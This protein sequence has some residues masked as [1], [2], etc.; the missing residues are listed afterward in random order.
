MK[1]TNLVIVSFIAVGLFSS[2]VGG[3]IYYYTA[4]DLME[5]KIN[6]SLL[7]I[8]ESR[9]EH[10]ETL[11]EQLR[12]SVEIAATHSELTTEELQYIREIEPDFFEIFVMD[13]NGVIVTSTDSAKVGLDR[14]DDEY[15]VE[16]RE[17]THLKNFY[18]SEDTQRNAMAIST[19]HAGGVLVARF[20]L[21]AL[22]GIARDRTGLGETGEVLVAVKEDDELV[23][24]FDRL[25]E[26]DVAIGEEFSE[27]SAE[28][29]T[30]ALLGNELIFRSA[31]DYRNV[32][33]IAA[34]QYI[35]IIDMGLVAK[36]DHEEI[37]GSY[38]QLLIKNSIFI[39]IL[40]VLIS[41]LI[42]IIVFRKKL[43]AIN[44]LEEGARIIGDGN[45][46]HRI[47][48]QSKDEIG[49]L[50]NSFNKMAGKLKKSY[51]GL[52]QRVN[53]RT[54]ELEYAKTGLEKKVQEQTI[55]LQKRNKDL[56]AA[57]T[58]LEKKVQEQTAEIQRKLDEVES[59]NKTM[60]GREL[61]MVE[62]K[63]KID[64]LNKQKT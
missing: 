20:D 31:L 17:G 28:P 61:K 21:A 13:A 53:E 12:A 56:L 64:T 39:G 41:I 4:E 48:I 47:D 36:I 40:I 19:P 37:V 52:E 24:V 25:F 7:A 10:I 11:M 35:P 16:A 22:E 63:K 55:E 57:K 49:K 18:F 3:V 6:N 26:E 44:I 46:D 38:R 43:K 8:A 32:P 51:A 30:Q 58:G 54:M 60:V 34:S 33:V 15:F 62:L 45:L 27:K 14:S 9:A 29:M 1:L 59:I 5:E 2:L 42:G 23:F 50:T